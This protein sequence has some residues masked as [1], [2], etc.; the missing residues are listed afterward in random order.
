MTVRDREMAFDG[1]RRAAAHE[2]PAAELAECH[3]I[4]AT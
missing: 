2:E 1:F 3:R 4:G